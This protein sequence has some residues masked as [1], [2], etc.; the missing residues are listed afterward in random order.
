VAAS[1]FEARLGTGAPAVAAAHVAGLLH[2]IGKAVIAQH[3]PE[4]IPPILR[5]MNDEAL[6]SS[7]A[8]ARVLDGATHAE[9]GAILADQW[10]LPASL[11]EAIAHHHSPD[12]ADSPVVH[13]V[14]LSDVACNELGF[15]SVNVKYKAAP[16]PKSS[17]ALDFDAEMIEHIGERLQKQRGLLGAVAGGALS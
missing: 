14:H 16:H 7:E 17:E 5:L 1:A 13:V 12:H 11:V 8:E 6:S 2:D 10:E 4:A 15:H 9:I 3:F